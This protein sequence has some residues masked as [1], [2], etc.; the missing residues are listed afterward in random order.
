MCRLSNFR[1]V[2]NTY[3]FNA[4]KINMYENLKLNLSEPGFS[5]GG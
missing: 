2:S 3:S 1:L 5:K 4:N